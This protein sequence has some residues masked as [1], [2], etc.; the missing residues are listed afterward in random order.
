MPCDSING[1][2]MTIL[3]NVTSAKDMIGGMVGGV[4]LDAE[5]AETLFVEVLNGRV[6]AAGLGAMLTVMSVRGAKVDELVGGARAMRRHVTPVESPPGSVVIDTCGTGGAPKLFNVST[7]GAIVGAAAA[8]GR[9]LVAKHGS[10]SRTGRGSAEVLEKL[11]VNIHASAA[12]QARCLREIGVCFSFAVNHHPAMKHVMP[13][14]KSLGFPTVFNL[15]GPLCNP[16]GVKR[17]LVGTYRPDLAAKLSH[18][19][20]RLGVEKAMVVTS[21]DG[22][23]EITTTDLTYVHEVEKGGVRP[24]TFDAEDVGMRRA[25]IEELQVGSLEEAAGVFGEVLNGKGGA[26]LNLTLLNAAGALVVGGCA[27]TIDEGVALA[28]EAVASGRARE[29][30]AGLVRLSGE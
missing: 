29:T 13:V 25:R 4:M 14:R 16:A 2:E 9:M 8:G 3:S 17:Q 11:G 28:Q 24:W 12:A 30:L 23:D 1:G 10:L 15:L 26:K 21:A 20:L 6:D 18:A 7:I 27:E 5:A 22:L 19:L